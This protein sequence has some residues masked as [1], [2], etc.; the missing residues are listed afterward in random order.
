MA[1]KQFKVIIPGE[2]G[3]G[4]QVFYYDTPE[5]LQ[6]KF[7]NAQTHATAKIRELSGRLTT[8]EQQLAATNQAIAS[9]NN[10]VDRGDFFET[11][12]KDPREAGKQLLSDIFGAPIDAVINDYAT[13]VRPAA[14]RSNIAAVDNEFVRQHPELM[15]VSQQ[16]DLHNATAIR[17]IIIERGWNYDVDTLNDA[18]T[19]AAQ[20]GQLKLHRINV[21]PSSSALPS[22]PTTVTRPSSQPN[23]SESEQ[24]FYQTAKLSDMRAYIEKKF[25]QQ[26]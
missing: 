21:Q 12:Y 19:I 16:D 7:V 8:A 6:E 26:R 14:Q 10:G 20:Q 11:F 15:E 18:Y 24:K 17:N 9:G 5:E 2:N 25:G 22:V 3:G 1:E 23:T 13:V 4:D